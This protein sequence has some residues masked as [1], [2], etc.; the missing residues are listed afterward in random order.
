[1]GPGLPEEP[2]R[3]VAQAQIGPQNGQD[4]RVTEAPETTADHHDQQGDTRDDHRAV[5]WAPTEGRHEIHS[6]TAVPR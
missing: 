5:G 6:A 1:M 2:G 3:R 4:E